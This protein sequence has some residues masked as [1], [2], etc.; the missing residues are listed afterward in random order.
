M[1]INVNGLKS[2][3]LSDHK[4][5]PNEPNAVDNRSIVPSGINTF[6]FF[7]KMGD[8]HDNQP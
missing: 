8:E 5:V 1:V 6:I 3:R 7:T 4:Y 2:S